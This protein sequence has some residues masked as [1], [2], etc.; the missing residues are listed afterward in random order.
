MGTNNG[1][2]ELAFQEWRHFKEAFTPELVARAIDEHPT[3]VT[4]CLDPFGGSG[5]TAIACQ[6]LGV[7]PITIE[8]NPYLADLIEAKLASYDPD[9]LVRDLGRVLRSAVR[10][11]SNAR[12]NLSEEAPATMV[13]PG[14]NNR[15]IFDAPVASRLAALLAAI[16]TLDNPNHQRLFRVLLGGILLDVSNVVVNGK[17][18]RY[19]CR[20]QE[21]R[22]N[23]ASVEQ[24][25]SESVRR[26]IADVHRFGDRSCL[27]GTVLRG[28]ARQKLSEVSRCD[29]VIFSPPYPNSF[30]YTD[31]YNLELWVL[32]Y[33]EDRE[34]NRELRR[35][36][37]CSHVQINRPYPQPPAGSPML[38]QV[39]HKLHKRADQLWHRRIPDMIGGYFTDLVAILEATRA[40]LNDRGR[41]WM[42]VGD[43]RYAQVV[44][45]TASILS[46]FAG[47]IGYRTESI[48]PFRSMRSSAQQGGKHELDESLVVLT[49]IGAG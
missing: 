47:T 23:E 34:K 3:P 44:I 7:E 36:T 26:A 11:R 33:L 49:P 21:R 46:E 13:E 20:W 48:E 4:R 38:T 18:R 32:G 22:R 2:P 9:A 41:V 42:V 31:V 29:L 15:W 17:G 39:L 40:V 5:T 16:Q 28:D 14:V 37:L 25:F 27:T 30:D 24:Y 43:S 12:L 19:R 45:P 8:V 10:H 1:A 6:F 35:S